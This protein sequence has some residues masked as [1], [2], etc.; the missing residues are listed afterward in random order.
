MTPVRIEGASYRHAHQACH[1][2]ALIWNELVSALRDHWDREESD[3]SV[4]QLRDVM[5]GLDPLLLDGLHAHTKQAIVDDLV[6]AVATY[7]ANRDNGDAET[8]APWRKK[9]YRPLEFTHDYGWR[10]TRDGGLMLSM[11]RKAK[12]I[13]LP[14]P[15]VIDP[16]TGKPIPDSEWG[17]IQ[18]CWDINARRWSLHIAVPAGKPKTGDPH[19]M[20]GIDE[21]IINPMTIAVETTN[22]YEVLVINGRHSRAVKH[23][24]N[25]RIARLQQ[26]L[27]RCVEGSKRWRK[28]DAKRKKIEARAKNAIL[29][30]DH[31]ASRKAADF[32][33]RHNAGQII[34]GDVR[35]IER[36]T[37]K[38]EDK[39]VKNKKGQR[40]RL[41]Q[42]SRGRQE[43][44]LEYKTGLE[45]QHIDEAYSSKTCP[46]CL[47]RNHPNGRGYHC[48]TCGFNCNRDAVGAINILNRAQ[49]GEYKPIDMDK[50][51]HV[52]Y[53]RATPITT[54]RHGVKPGTG[55]LPLYKTATQSCVSLTA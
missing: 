8:R 10:C 37:R 5:Y 14:L 1:Q 35:D 20:A 34:A 17:T 45:V 42:W 55:T 19:V 6:D 30:A 3:P 41:S 26:K 29:N 31:Q 33:Q 24:R 4:K 27:S 54:G 39:R 46:A 52:T 48:R 7:R 49:Y 47:A 22:A 28:L 12:P 9:N 18:L 25:T 36:N 2:A 21:G 11:G 23:Y 51:I 44:L 53:L 15:E 13:I 40:R 32:I 16:K 43:D 50:P 38:Q